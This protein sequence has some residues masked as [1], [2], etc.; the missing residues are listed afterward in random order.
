V[1]ITRG[2]FYPAGEEASFVVLS[3]VWLNLAVLGL[4]FAVFLFI[5]TLLFVRAER[6]R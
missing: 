4:S 1:D 5:G 2:L 6:N 3:P